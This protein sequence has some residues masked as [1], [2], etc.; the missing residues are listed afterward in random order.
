MKLTFLG[1]G[2]SQGVPVIAGKHD[3]L[4]L[5]NP[6]NWRTRSSIHIQADGKHVQV[7]AGPEFRLQCLQNK[8]DWIDVF[9]LT[10]GHT[11]HIVGMD[12]LRRFCDRMPQNIMPVFSNE[13]GL[14]RVAAIFPYAMGE[15]PTQVGYP[16]FKCS[17]MPEKLA[18]SENFFVESVLLP[19]GGVET[20]GLIFDCSGKRIAYYTD[21]H[22]VE[23]RAAE[24][25]QGVDIL[26]LDFLRRREHP[27]HLSTRSAL[28][29]ARRLSPKQ[30]YFTHTTGEIDYDV[31]RKALPENYEVAYDGL[32]VE[33]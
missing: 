5:S 23:G 26:I 13:Y 11:D 21:C 3:G 10:H 19:H 32:S 28:E 17:L 18:I 16:C 9:I 14:E 33:L 22:A 7:D 31:W 1:T 30:V 4:D 12:D 20:L 24:L 27:A 29:I 2:T 25:A 6:K 8:I 15:K